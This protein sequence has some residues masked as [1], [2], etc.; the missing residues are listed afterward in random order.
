MKKFISAVISCCVIVFAMSFSGTAEAAES[1]PLYQGINGFSSEVFRKTYNQDGYK[2]KNMV[3]S[4]LSIYSD[5]AM[6]NNGTANNTHSEILSM[7]Q[8]G[9]PTITQA[10][11]NDFFNQYMQ[12]AAIDPAVNMASCVYLSDDESLHVN[13]DFVETVKSFYDAEVFSAPPDQTTIARINNWA[14]ENTNEAIDEVVNPE[15]INP[16]TAAVLLNA[17]AFDGVWEE[18]YEEYQIESEQFTNYD[19]SATQVD[20]LTD[21]ADGYYEDEMSVA[22]SRPYQSNYDFIGILPNEDVGVDK[23]IESMDGNTIGKLLEN[24]HS[25]SFELKVVTKIPKFE[26]DNNIGLNETLQDMGMNEAFSKGQADLSNLATW[27]DNIFVTSVEQFSHIKLD[28]NGTKAEA[29]TGTVTG[30]SSVPRRIS[31]YL[32]RPFVFVIYDKVNK[33]PLFIGTVCDMSGNASENSYDTDVTAD[34]NSSLSESSDSSRSSLVSES[35]NTSKNGSASESSSINKNASVSESSNSTIGTDES[36]VSESETTSS[37]ITAANNKH[38]VP[39]TGA[40]VGGIVICLAV[41][42]FLAVKKRSHK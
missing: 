14:S 17:I 11:L 13:Q 38:T 22:F 18:P 25:S 34:R 6:F 29:V 40:I 5:I 30:T 39:Y 36:I 32:D 26:F 37:D 7:L 12:R 16:Y 23:Y 3:M 1:N 10:S 24:Y 42:S 8:S 41:I 21:G 20:F 33:M 19:G 9:D 4:P 2:G 27:T 31:I 15:V 35:S 28:E